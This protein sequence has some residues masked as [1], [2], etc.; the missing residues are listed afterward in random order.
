MTTVEPCLS[1][2]NHASAKEGGIDNKEDYQN[3]HHTIR[4]FANGELF[5]VMKC[6]IFF[7]PK[8]PS[9][10]IIYQKKNARKKN[11]NNLKKILNKSE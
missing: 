2:K 10:D 7:L 11:T 4:K 6:F 5:S 8:T 3:K 9:E 1:T